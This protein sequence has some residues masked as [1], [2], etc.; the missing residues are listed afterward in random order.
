MCAR[1]QVRGAAQRATLRRYE[2]LLSTARTHELLAPPVLRC[3]SLR[4]C[5]APPA[6]IVPLGAR[7]RPA[8]HSS[9][10]VSPLVAPRWTPFLHQWSPA[11][12]R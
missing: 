10:T 12:H 6:R 11:V 3:F 5:R 7:P 1:E 4:V 9:N 8:I 2:E